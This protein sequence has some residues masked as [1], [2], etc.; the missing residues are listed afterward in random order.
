MRL[1]GKVAIVTGGGSGFGEGIARRFA[2][3]GAAV[4]VN[5]I[6]RDGGERVAGGIVQDGGRALFVQS[7]VSKSEGVG[8]L[9]EAAIRAFGQIDC[10]VNNAG[11]THRNQP[12]TEVS[13]AEFDRVFAVNVKAIYHAAIHCV[14]QFRRLGGGNFINIA[15]TAGLR[16]RPGLTWYNS[17]KGAVITMTKSMAV[18]LAADQIRVN[19]LCPVAGETPLLP[20]FMGRDDAETRERFLATI[21]LGR[22]STPADI[23]NAALWLASD[24]AEFITGIAMEVDGGRS[25]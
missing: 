18:E 4:I 16:P 24:E 20:S 12:L 11:V 6:S 14:P 23:A 22:F 1:D 3:E 25:V 15:S 2:G 10:M 5:D 17:T 7:D 13:E 21:P 8:V 19:C 9:V